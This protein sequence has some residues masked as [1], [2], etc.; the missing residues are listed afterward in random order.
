VPVEITP[1][2]IVKIPVA[3]PDNRCDADGIKETE[4]DL[5]VCKILGVN[6]TRDNRNDNTECRHEYQPEPDIIDIGPCTRRGFFYVDHV[7][8]Q[9]CSFSLFDVKFR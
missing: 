6:H 3:L 4:F 9:P 2:G 7:F 5:P 1:H 8:F